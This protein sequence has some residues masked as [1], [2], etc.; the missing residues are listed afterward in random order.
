MLC[1]NRPA[2]HVLCPTIFCACAAVFCWLPMCSICCLCCCSWLDCFVH[3]FAICCCMQCQCC[4]VLLAHYVLFNMLLCALIAVPKLCWVG[5]VCASLAVWNCVLGLCC[6]S[7]QVEADFEGRV[8]YVDISSCFEQ[9]QHC[10]TLLA[11]YVICFAICHCVQHLCCWA[12]Q[13]S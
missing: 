7:S 9:C 3:C 13:A 4:W 2:S 8:L 1:C 12:Q 11:C 6:S 5:S 10:C